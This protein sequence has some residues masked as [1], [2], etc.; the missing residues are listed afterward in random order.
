MFSLG[1]QHH[2]KNMT[3]CLFTM[4]Y[5]QKQ[6]WM[7]LVNIKFWKDYGSA[8]L[9]N[10]QHIT[11]QL[12]QLL[13]MASR[14]VQSPFSTKKSR[15]HLSVLFLYHQEQV[16]GYKDTLATESKNRQDPVKFKS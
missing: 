1:E 15:E 2:N 12:S 13:L 14:H 16:N 9:I 3:M 11:S 10:L 4:T 5:K 7:Y 6:I 8:L